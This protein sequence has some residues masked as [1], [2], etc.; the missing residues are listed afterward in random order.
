MREIDPN[1]TTRKLAYSLWMKAPN[2]TV[3]F[4]KTYDV[5][6]LV[7]KCKK[8]NLKLNMLLCYCIGKSA[9]NVK[10]FY[11]LPI[12][13]KLFEFDKI[14]VSVVIKNKENGL[15]SCDIPFMED[16]QEFNNEYLYLTNKVRESC[17]NYDLPDYMAVG[18]SA[19]LNVEIDGAVNMYSGTLNNPFVIWGRYKEENG[20]FLLKTSFQFHHTQM[21]GEQAGEFL[22]NLEDEIKKF[23]D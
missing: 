22:K 11:V 12:G 23:E 10:E 8:E 6:P 19:I 9:I 21:D 5:T 7:E 1:L 13:D 16:L 4:F 14:A 17:E 18:T 3:T 2:P 20:K 15:C